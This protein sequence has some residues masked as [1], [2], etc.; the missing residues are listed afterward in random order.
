MF[1]EQGLNYCLCQKRNGLLLLQK[2]NVNS[3]LA[4][5]LLKIIANCVSR[6]FEPEVSLVLKILT[7]VNLPSHSSP[8]KNISLIL[9]QLI[10]EFWSWGLK[11]VDS[12]SY[13]I[14]KLAK[15]RLVMIPM[16]S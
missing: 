2:K 7:N 1:K 5:E 9:G 13:G 12:K 10:R 16:I 14:C 11:I 6:P 15:K 3:L 8:Q 4:N